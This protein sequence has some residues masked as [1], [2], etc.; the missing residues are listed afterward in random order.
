MKAVIW[1]GPRQM[2]YDNIQQP[3]PQAGQALLR[4][5][6]VGICGSELSGYLGQNSLR[7]PPLIMGHEFAGKV[8][9]LGDG[10]E[11]LQVGDVVAVNPLITCGQCAMCRRGLENLCLERQIFGAHCPGAFAEYVAVPAVNCTALPIGLTPVAGSLA[12]PLACG[13]R[14]ADIAGIEAGSHVVILGAG[15]IGLLAI[16]TVQA[17]G[18]EVTLTAEVNPARLATAEVWGAKATVD[19]RNED[20]AHVA[21]TLTGGLGADIV[22]DAVGSTTTRQTA[23]KA[24]RPGGIAVFV[25][26]HE[27]ASGLPANHIVRSEIKVTGSFAYTKA[28]FA[29]AVELLAAGAIRPSEEWLEERELSACADSFAELVDGSPTY[30]KIVLRPSWS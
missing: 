2:I 20:P 21:R 10:V 16:A 14:A 12:E 9:S 4:V 23:I 1:T 17:A 15:A 22:I 24:L 30:S 18:G 3:E 26:L 29:T 6:A 8:V 13:V 27:P 7:V 28:D 19:A 5:Q 25:G 11:H